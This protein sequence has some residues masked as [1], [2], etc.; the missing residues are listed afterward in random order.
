MTTLWD[1]VYARREKFKKYLHFDKLVKIESYKKVISSF[2][3][4]LDY[5]SSEKYKTYPLLKRTEYSPKFKEDFTPTGESRRVRTKSKP[6]VFRYPSHKEAFF[7]YCYGYYLQEEYEKILKQENLSDIV[8]AYRKIPLKTSLPTTKYRG[9]Q[10]FANE[11]FDLIEKQGQCI[12][13]TL[14]IEK[15]FDRINHNKLYQTWVD[16][17]ATTRLHS[18]ETFLKHRQLSVGEYRIY[19]SLTKYQSFN[20]KKVYQVLGINRKN[21]KEYFLKKWLQICSPEDFRTKVIPL[22]K[23]PFDF[24]EKNSKCFGIPQGSPLSP[25]LSNLYLL[26]FDKQINSYL[27]SFGG[28]YRRYCDDILVVIPNIKESPKIIISFIENILTNLELGIAVNNDKTEIVTFKKDRLSGKIQS[29]NEKRKNCSLVYL[30]WDFDGNKR[31]LRKRTLNR[32]YNKARKRIFKETSKLK[33]CKKSLPKKKIYNSYGNERMEKILPSKS[34]KSKTNFASY[35]RYSSS[36]DLE[37][38]PNPYVKKQFKKAS[39][40]VGKIMK[41]AEKKYSKNE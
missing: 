31:L 22:N 36:G 38:S 2:S 4:L 17:L 1:E 7:H 9:V 25:I 33:G 13:I 14:D 10:H 20:K 40:N 8:L 29:E 5:L 15:F 37:V 34:P 23:P 30:G 35:I 26:E 41:K 11:I 12:V 39:L 27:Q 16:F 19:K 6:R 18:D 28:I 3:S 21:E 24:Y 32:F